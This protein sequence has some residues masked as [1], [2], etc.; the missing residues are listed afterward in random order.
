MRK[1]LIEEAPKKGFSL[2]VTH[3]DEQTGLVTHKDPYILRIIGEKDS[4]EKQR[5]WERPA[6]SGNLWDKQNNP[7]GRWVYEEKTVKGK[8]VKVGSHDPDAAHIAY[9]APLTGDQK[10]RQEMSQDKVK[11]A[12]LERELASIKAEKD[13]KAAPAATPKKDQGA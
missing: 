13:K 9:V 5:L 8:K 3:R 6:G 10:L 12:E 7:V 4:N 2:K 11:L 1:P